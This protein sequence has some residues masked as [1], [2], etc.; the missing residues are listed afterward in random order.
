MLGDVGGNE[1][2]MI[3]RGRICH[4]VRNLSI[5]YK[6]KLAKKVSRTTNWCELEVKPWCFGC[7]V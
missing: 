6:F 5:S 2:I 1:M 3:Y 7:S 4:A